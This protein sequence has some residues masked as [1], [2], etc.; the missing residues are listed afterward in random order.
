MFIYYINNLIMYSLTNDMN[1]VKTEY[2]QI[3]IIT[4]NSAIRNW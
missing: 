4:I 2:K 3:I 1:F